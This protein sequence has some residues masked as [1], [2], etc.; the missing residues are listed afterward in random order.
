MCGDLSPCGSC[1][2][3]RV[4]H[5]Y[6]SS[7]P[8]RRCNLM[9]DEKSLIHL[10]VSLPNRVPRSTSETRLKGPLQRHSCTWKCAPKTNNDHRSRQYLST[11]F[12]V[13]ERMYVS[14]PNYI[15]WGLEKSEP[16][17]LLH[18]N[19][20]MP[21]LSV[22]EFFFILANMFSFGHSR[23]MSDLPV[24]TTLILFLINGA[25]FMIAIQLPPDLHRRFAYAPIIYGAGA[26]SVQASSHVTWLLGIISGRS[27]LEVYLS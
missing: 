27:T 5:K 6:F 9:H 25:A 1:M 14:T 3:L 7:S 18:G 4:M 12:V 21:Q 17:T 19:P 2:N 22:T 24:L 16:R 13:M 10:V 23:V 8:P 26:L 15:V 11:K 20:S